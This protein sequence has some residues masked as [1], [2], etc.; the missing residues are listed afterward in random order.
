MASTTNLREKIKSKRKA[1]Q[2]S[3]TRTKDDIDTQA[4]VN[5]EMGTNKESQQTAMKSKAE[6]VLQQETSSESPRR[7][8]NLRDTE[9]VTRFD[10]ELD[11]DEFRRSRDNVSPLSSRVKFRDI[12][13]KLKQKPQTQTGFPTAEEAYNF[14]TFNFDPEPP[15]EKPKKKRRSRQDQEEGEE[16]EAQE[17]EEEE[18]E[19]EETAVSGEQEEEAEKDE[20]AP[21]VKDQ[22]EDLF[23]IDQTAQDFLEYKAAECED[24]NSRLLK[25]NE[26]LFT[27]SILTVPASHKVP[28]NKQPRFLEDEGLYVGERPEVSLANQNI[29]EN[30][31]L[32]QEEGKRW[33][34]DDGRIMALP[35]PI[36]E[37]STRPP[38]FSLEEDVD[39]ALETVYRKA[40]KSKYTNRYIIGA[41]DPQGDFQ[42]DIDVSGLIFIHHPLFSREHVLAAKLAQMYD[43]YLTRQQKNLTSLLTDKLH[44]LRNAIRNITEQHNGQILNPVMQHRISEYRFEIRHTRKLRD[45]EQ[46]KDR[47]L[48][49]GIVKIWKEIKA[50]RDFQRFTNTPLKLCLRRCKAKRKKKKQ[51]QQAEEEDEDGQEKGSDEELG[52]EPPKPD[53]PGEL[54]VAVLEQQVREK[55]NLS[56]RKPGESNLIAEL[57]SAGSVTPNELCP[58]GE[59][60]RREDTQKRSIYTKVLYNNKEVSRTASRTLNSDF[61]VHFGQIFNLKIVNWPES[62][63]LQVFEMVGSSSTMLAEVYVPLPDTTVLTG[64]APSEELEFSSNHRVMFDHEGVG[65]DVPFSFEADGSNKLIL[66]TSGKLSCS[67][68]WAVGE[69]GAPLVPPVSQQTGG[70]Q[71]AIK[72]LDAI[73]CIGTSGVSDMKKLAKWAAESRLDPNDPSNAALMQLLTIATSGEVQIPDFFRLEQ[74]QEE[75]NFASEDELQRSKRFRLLELRSQ[76]VAEFR[77]YKRVPALDREISEKVFQEYEKRLHEREII[78]TSDHLDAHRALVAKYLQK[79]RES[80]INRF[81]IAKH[82]YLLSDLVVEEEVPSIGVLGISLFKLAEPKRPLKPRRKERKKV[83]AQNLSDGDIK[84]LINVIRAYDIPIRKPNTSKPSVASRS[85]R[86]FT[87]AFAA[88]QPSQSPTQSSDLPLNQVCFVFHMSIH[89]MLCRITFRS[90]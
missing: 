58:R 79:V 21:L 36:K 5:S 39:P 42:L 56:R 61:R 55:A 54:D 51:Q 63:K 12:V 82:H 69:N 41:G 40:V 31:L 86:S 60:M 57:T 87:E 26:V 2:E 81:L 30:R 64:N 15:E 32:R 37:S 59:I 7:L 65:S 17:E 22:D 83:T 1:L 16:E 9:T 48:L 62:V 28:E 24:Y 72:Q 11:D 70:I 20:D 74:L 19:E 44:A 68:S 29:L 85:A 84:L 18:E 10:T 13:N 27:P 67:V 38:V 8:K 25:E 47:T 76:E 77:N 71:S 49:K 90:C 52:E 43:Q 23:I 73:A 35:N 50:L 14:F 46:E 53:P 4:L 66:L 33:F 75:F 78:D 80:V 3:L 45:V 89:N 6:S 88:G 34:G